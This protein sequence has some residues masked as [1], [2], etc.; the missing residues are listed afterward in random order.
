MQPRI[1]ISGPIVGLSYGEAYLNS[2]KVENKLIEL[3]ANNIYNPTLFID[4]TMSMTD[5]IHFRLSEL[6]KCELAI[7]I[8]GWQQCEISRSEFHAA[9]KQ[10]LHIRYDK[11][12]SY[13]DI[14]RYFLNPQKHQI[15]NSHY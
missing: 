13:I 10:G 4:P 11:R 7:F 2:K 8:D 6:K 12:E 15:C 14:E 1:Y 3:G 9:N 5:Q